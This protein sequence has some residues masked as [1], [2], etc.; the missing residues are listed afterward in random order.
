MPSQQ[1]TMRPALMEEVERTNIVV[2]R[3]SGQEMGAPQR[4]DPYTMKVNCGRN[5]YTYRG[6]GHMGCH[7]RNQRQRG[8]VVDKRRLEYGEENT[9]GNYE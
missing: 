5:C 7:C 3:G 2:V 8:R 4:R 6:F 1:A 9:K